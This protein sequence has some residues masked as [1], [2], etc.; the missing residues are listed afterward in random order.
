MGC[1]AFIIIRNS[2]RRLLACFIWHL[3]C[4]RAHAKKARNQETK[5]VFLTG[6][7]SLAAIVPTFPVRYK[8]T[9]RFNGNRWQRRAEECWTIA[10]GFHDPNT[11]G[12]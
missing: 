2:A 4:Y 5:F 7:C 12:S 1:E 3:F 8:E 11:A 9:T 10:D 6:R